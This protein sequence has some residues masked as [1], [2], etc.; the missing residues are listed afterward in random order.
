MKFRG[1]DMGRISKIIAVLCSLIL[2]ST[3]F[4]LASAEQKDVDRHVRLETGS[5]SEWK[6]GDYVAINMTQNGTLAWFG[7]VYGN[8]SNH[9]CIFLVSMFV[10][11]L[12]GAE[13]RDEHGGMMVPAIGIPVVTVFIQ[14]LAMLVEFNDTGYPSL[15]GRVGADNGL[16]D[17]SR[18]GE[19]IDDFNISATEPL[20]KAVDLNRSWERSEILEKSVVG[21]EQQKE[22]E[23]S[24]SARDVSYDKVWDVSTPQDAVVEKI[25]F[26]FHIGARVSQENIMVPWYRVTL[27]DDNHV[28]SSEETKSR[29]YK[30][31]GNRGLGL[32]REVRN[33]EADARESDRIR[34][35]DTGHR[36]G[37]DRRPVRGGL[38]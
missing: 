14:A 34:N 25:E 24:L 26:K 3:T 9:N 15:E 29:L 7:V 12:G 27:D 13:I 32:H 21:R 20:Y 10:R 23:F 19:G 5:T 16:F 6:G 17:F 31:V 4:G 33:F 2:M 35:I 30:G 11:Y 22:W 8:E 1:N 36:P 38:R 28:V 37:M 18:E